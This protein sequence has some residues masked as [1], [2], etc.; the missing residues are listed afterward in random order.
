MA[1]RTH[2]TLNVEIERTEGEFRSEIAIAQAIADSVPKTIH[3]EGS[4]YQVMSIARWV[5]S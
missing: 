1:H 2:L 3:V 4:T 5:D